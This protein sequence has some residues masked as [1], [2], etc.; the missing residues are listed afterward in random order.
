MPP[1]ETGPHRSA[2]V[3]AGLRRAS[4]SPIIRKSVENKKSDSIRMIVESLNIALDT[5][6]FVE[7][8]PFERDQVQAASSRDLPFFAE[9]AVH[10]HRATP[11]TRATREFANV[12]QI[13]QDANHS[14]SE[15][16]FSRTVQS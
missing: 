14:S 12:R 2:S 5:P 6:A 3:R 13:D 7:N 16:D 9:F 1:A 11:W 4:S 15:N 10:R 8:R